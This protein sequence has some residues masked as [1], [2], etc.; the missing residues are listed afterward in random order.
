M[1]YPPKPPKP[2]MWLLVNHTKTLLFLD[3]SDGGQLQISGQ[4]N[5]N[6]VNGAM[7]ITINLWLEAKFGD[8]RKPLRVFRIYFKGL[9]PNFSFNNNR[10]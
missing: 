9:S 10:I 3:V 1:I 8:A 4:L 6:T 7:P 2:N 5:N